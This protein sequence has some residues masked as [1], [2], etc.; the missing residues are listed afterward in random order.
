MVQDLYIRQ[1]VTVGL[2]KNKTLEG[3]GRELL[4]LMMMT[5]VR[6]LI[7]RTPCERLLARLLA[8]DFSRETPCKRLLGAGGERKNQPSTV[9]A[10][11]MDRSAAGEG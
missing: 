7:P 1:G 4:F 10:K 3:F 11:V 6:S 5:S 2:N 9:V 8:R